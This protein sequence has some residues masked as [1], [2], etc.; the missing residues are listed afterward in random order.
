MS[1]KQLL[2]A[3]K[4]AIE[5]ED[6]ESAIEYADEA[7]Q[8]DPNCYYAHIFKGKSY[9]LLSQWKSAAA[10]F[11]QAI[12]IEPENLLGWKGYFQV[13]KAQDDTQ[14][15]FQIVT[16]YLKVLIDQEIGI[17]QVVKDVYNYLN[18][19]QYQKEP[20]LHEAFL[21][22]ILPGTELGDLLD[23]AMG[24][25]EDT[26]KKLILLV[27]SREANELRNV[28]AK[29][30]LK[31]PRVLTP[32]AQ[33]Q[34][35][36]VEWLVRRP[37]DLSGLYSQFL[38]CC[39]DDDLRHQYE[40]EYLKYRYD[41]LRVVPNK[42]PVMREIKEMCDDM[43]LINTDDVLAWTLYFDFAD[44]VTLADLDENTVLRFIAK[45]DTDGLANVLLAYTMSDMCVFNRDK[46]KEM[47]AKRNS[48]ES[49][50][51]D[52]LEPQ[53][54]VSIENSAIETV[55]TDHDALFS[56][57]AI[58]DLMQH[59]SASTTSV[60][61][62]RIVCNYYIHLHAYEEASSKCSLAIR[63]LA[64]LQRTYGISLAHCRED[65]LCLL[66]TVYTYHEAPKNYA[67]ALEL[68]ERI[69]SDN[70]HNKDALIGKGLILLEKRELSQALSI[71]SGV[72]ELSPDWRA[73][74][75]LGWCHVMMKQYATG[76]ETLQQALALI[77]GTSMAL[78]EARAAV[79]WRLAKS[80]LMEEANEHS[81]QSAYDLLILA[82]RDFKNHAPSYTLLGEI[83]QQHH[84][85]TVRAQKCFY[86]AFELDVGEVTAA[87]HLVADLAAKNE[88]DVTEIL[89]RRVVASE[90]SRRV[91]FSQLNDDADK[92]WPY[93]VLGCSALNKQDDAKAIE[94]FQ[95]ALRMKA[96]DTACWVGLGEAYF[97][98]GRIDAAI[99]VFQH[100]TQT[101]ASW[102][103]FYFLG[104]AVC[105]IGDFASGL[106]VL[107]KALAMSAEEC[108]LNALYEKLIAHSAQLLQGGFVGR[109]VRANIYALEKIRAAASVNVASQSLWKALGDCLLMV[110]Q[111]QTDIADF[112]VQT[113]VEV[114]ELAQRAGASGCVSKVD[115]ANV[116][117][118]VSVAEAVR[119]FDAGHHIAA[120][121]MLHVLAAQAAIDLLPKKVSKYLRA[122]A[123]FNMGTALLD[124]EHATPGVDHDR[125]SNYRAAAVSHLKQAIHIE[126]SNAQYWVALALAH[127]HQPHI[128]QHCLIKAGALDTRDVG[129]WTHLAAVYLRHGDAE[130]AAEAFERAT[131]LAPDQSA[132]WLGNALAAEAR[133]DAATAARLT[134]HAY[135]SSH[136]RSAPAQLCYAASVASTRV[137][138]SGDPRDVAAAQEFSIANY[139]AQ[140]F[141]AAQPES[142]AALQLA[143]VLSERC[144]N[145]ATSTQI[146]NKLCLVLET[147]YEETE[148][149]E[150]FLQYAAAK[151]ALARVCLGAE[152]YEA[153]VDHAQGALDM[154]GE[155]ASQESKEENDST[156]L[157]RID[158]SSRIVIGLAFFF[159]GQFADAV[160]EFRAVLDAHSTSR[161]AVTLVAQ[162][163]YA[164]GTPDAKQAAVDQ[165]FSFIAESGSS[166]MV[167]LTLGALAVADDLADYF[168]PIREELA[169]LSVEDLAGDTSRLVPQLAA[170]LARREHMDSRVWQ[171]FALLFPGDYTVQRNLSESTALATALLSG[172]KRSAGDVARSY[173][174]L[175]TRREMQ[176][177]L[178]LCG[179][180]DDVR[181]S[182]M[183]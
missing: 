167:V 124:A 46:V 76:R 137:G 53:E 142:V 89:C 30:K 136:G 25:E 133:G 165:L 116:I 34:L 6:P 91:L 110:R 35:N 12:K 39:H 61:A 174:A 177:A 23:G 2:K 175:G 114:L 169:A 109:T 51:V 103:S 146:G 58:L 168:E 84:G 19:R 104:L 94:W 9:Q 140:S 70:P 117:A 47:L 54:T 57:E 77:S 14:K 38:R 1:L 80:Y 72:A 120:V 178:L 131:S 158:L 182:L 65:V 11:E 173:A 41:I 92:S 31:L 143:L 98:C 130:L 99:K 7:L 33:A 105:E 183:A 163:L 152:D 22:A 27:K 119:L 147:Q 73:L 90:R 67:R 55:E 49:A 20:E 118:G 83:Y 172:L 82:L 111:V 122:A 45:F 32:Q 126:D 129:V 16:G 176:R 18:A 180:M 145:Y 132:A 160:G 97:N 13:G 107:E 36:A 24:K 40:S 128:A 79:Q 71:L 75:E 179:D 155:I 96:M 113:V 135:V 150:V 95:T 115:C 138:Q 26:L 74:S 85:D 43:V 144:H 21:R 10:S 60:L 8:I 42:A 108:V 64:D 151:A 148:S 139:A 52:T 101:D 81:V 149:S 28:L 37:F 87:K 157:A 78:L 125:Q 15:F 170:E 69:L 29:E 161:R 88:W 123:H 66:A 159:N 121:A 86:K 68:Y 93:R 17:G 127:S 50:K 156:V 4:A 154:A 59:G 112:P 5:S 181:K 102:V 62:Q 44:P 134:T 56:P 63:Q 153:A 162:V 141:L 106:A 3:A 100:T 164:H 171:R 48:K 166:L